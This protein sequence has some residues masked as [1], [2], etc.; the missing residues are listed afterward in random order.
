MTAHVMTARR[1]AALKKAQIASA[2]RRRKNRTLKRRGLSKTGRKN[3][4][5]A[6]RKNPK[7]AAKLFG[8]AIFVGAATGLYHTHGRR[9][10]F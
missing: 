6:V 2:V 5:K 1:K 9:I 10:K 7:K 4:R 3:F 8:T